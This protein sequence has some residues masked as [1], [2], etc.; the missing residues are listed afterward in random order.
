M[1]ESREELLSTKKEDYK[2]EILDHTNSQVA[3]QAESHPIETKK[4]RE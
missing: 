3:P 1:N 2:N 4:N